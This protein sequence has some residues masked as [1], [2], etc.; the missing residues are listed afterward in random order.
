MLPTDEQHLAALRTYCE[1]HQAFSPMTKLCE[2]V[3]DA[4]RSYQSVK[5]TS[6]WMFWALRNFVSSSA[7][8][9]SLGQSARRPT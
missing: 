2:V 6:E 5:S 3:G 9:A 7:T 4:Y 8:I 1:R